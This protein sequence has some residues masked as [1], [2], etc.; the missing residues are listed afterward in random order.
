MGHRKLLSKKEVCGVRYDVSLEVQDTST[1]KHG[2][3]ETWAHSE[4]NSKARFIKKWI[5]ECFD[6]LN[7]QKSLVRVLS[8]D[9][10]QGNYPNLQEITRNSKRVSSLND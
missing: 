4:E 3:K 9:I 1:N 8:N 6:R 7:D 10:A 5:Q 2:G